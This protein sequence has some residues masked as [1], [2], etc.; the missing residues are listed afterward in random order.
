MLRACGL[1]QPGVGVTSHGSSNPLATVRSLLTAMLTARRLRQRSGPGGSA[2]ISDQVRAPARGLRN[3][4]LGRPVRLPAHR[5]APLT[6][7]RAEP[8]PHTFRVLAG[9]GRRLL[10][11]RRSIRSSTGCGARLWLCHVAV[12]EVGGELLH[13]SKGGRVDAR[14]GHESERG[15][16]TDQLGHHHGYADERVRSSRSGRCRQ[17][18]RV[19][20]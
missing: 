3:D 7:G 11:S 1:Q 18:S 19:P 10:A 17:M 5:G 15:V 16:R 14:P 20:W 12:A 4:S 13:G 6:L 9:S 2:S 8:T